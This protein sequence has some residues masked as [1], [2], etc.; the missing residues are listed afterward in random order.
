MK[1]LLQGIGIFLVTATAVAAQESHAVPNAPPPAE[2]RCTPELFDQAEK[3]FQFRNLRIYKFRAAKTHQKILSACQDSPLLPEV[4]RRISI[5]QEE[6]A[7]HFFYTA[8]YYLE[9]YRS[10][11][12]GLKGA[13]SRYRLVFEKYPTYSKIDEVIFLIGETY[14]LEK[15][16]KDAAEHFQIVINKFP[17]SEIAN[18]ANV[19]LEEIDILS[20]N[21]ENAPSLSIRKGGPPN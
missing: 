4:L 2:N 14:L 7:E 19:K 11:G 9:K 12:R 16:F 21:T 1:Y 15:N 17:G 6:L 3:E 10:E 18:R 20:K 13:Q 8:N 5:L